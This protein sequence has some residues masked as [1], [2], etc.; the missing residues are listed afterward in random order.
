MATTRRKP[1]WVPSALSNAS[2]QSD[3]KSGDVAGAE[4]PPAPPGPHQNRTGRSSAAQQ[5]FRPVS[6]LAPAYAPF[7]D[8]ATAAA[9]AV[10]LSGGTVASV[11]AARPIGTADGTAATLNNLSTPPNA[12][13]VTD[14]IPYRRFSSTTDRR[15]SDVRAVL[16]SVTQLTR[17]IAAKEAEILGVEQDLEN[18]QVRLTTVILP[19]VIVSAA[20]DVVDVVIAAVFAVDL[21]I[22]A[23]PCFDA[24]PT[25]DCND[26]GGH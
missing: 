24:R 14:P 10:A 19:S 23:L 22:V 26:A 21:D 13:D 17:D 9:A 11:N 2:V 15:G 6:T 4:S 25:R 18:V 3:S 20:A 8:A 1:S 16:E 7:G 5:A 12:A